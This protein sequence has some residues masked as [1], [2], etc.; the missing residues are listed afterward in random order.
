MFKVQSPVRI[1]V[2][3]GLKMSDERMYKERKANIA[4]FRGCDF[5]CCYCAFCNTLKRSKCKDDRDYKPHSHLEVLSKRPPPTKEGEFVTIGMNGDISFASEETMQAIIHYCWLWAKHTFLLQS[6]NPAFFHEYKFPE[7][8][9]LGTTMESNKDTWYST[10]NAT[11]L[12]SVVR[13]WDISKAPSNN[14]RFDAMYELTA[15]KVITIE[16]ILDFDMEPFI[17]AIIDLKP[18]WVWVGYDSKPER[19]YLPE[20]TLDKTQELI[21]ELTEAGIDVREKLLRKAWY[22]TASLNNILRLQ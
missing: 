4:A 11:L 6:K 18:E 2:C 3:G 14:K 9:I 20:P 13:Y 1:K 10:H 15:R 8:V 7:N 21:R 5:K 22:E 16:P 17:N 12:K 19:N